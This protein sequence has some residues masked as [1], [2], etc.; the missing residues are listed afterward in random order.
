MKKVTFISA[1]LFFV[2]QGCTSSREKS[3]LKNDILSDCNKAIQNAIVVD[4]ISAPVGARRYYYA[5]V[6]AYEALVPFYPSQKS[7]AGQLH[8]LKALPTVDTAKG[9]CLDLVALAAHTYVS[10]IVVYKEDSINSFRSRMLSWYKSQ[11]PSSTFTNSVS[12]GD[13]VGAHIAKWS[14]SDSFGYYRGRDFYLAKNANGFWQPTPSE[15]KQAVEPMWGHIRTAAVPLKPNQGSSVYGIAYDAD[16]FGSI[17]TIKVPKTICLLPDSIAK[18]QNLHSPWMHY[19][20]AEPFSSNKN[21]R[22]YALCKEV[23]DVVN[24]KDS[25][26]LRIAKYWDDNP[27]TT[28]HYGH[29]TINILKVSPAGHWLGMFSIVAQQK[30]YSLIES[31]E[32][33]AILSSAIH[34]A[35]VSCWK[36][37]YETEYVRPVTSIRQLIDSSWTPPIETPGFPEYP[38]GHSVVSSAA[39]TVLTHFF[40]E[41]EFTD[42]SEKEFG[43]GTRTFKNFRAA[44]NEACASRLYGGIH[45]IDAIEKGKILGN[46]V[47]DWIV[48]HLVTKR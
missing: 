22:F 39:A 18:Q 8:A 41:Y 9:Y 45:F 34:D 33:M 40:G 36:V 48:G 42:S 32:G 4:H 17:K 1:L 2:L 11:L 46:A 27:N 30:K 35:F 43:L 38:S 20:L 21:S 31:A 28:V 10:K 6:A 16:K 15:Y 5:S 24:R 23:Y 29:A 19:S 3:I 47:G 44:S 26:E 7:L 12:W 37:K 25:N 14:K 13:S